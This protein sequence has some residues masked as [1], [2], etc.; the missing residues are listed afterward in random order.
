MS[1]IKD[2]EDV[3]KEEVAQAEQL[4]PHPEFR[5]AIGE[6]QRKMVALEKRVA[7]LECEK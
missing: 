3:K 2:I 5:Q 1:L 6:L 4:L 7:E